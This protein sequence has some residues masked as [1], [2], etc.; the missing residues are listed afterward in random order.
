MYK[1]TKTYGWMLRLMSVAFL[2]AGLTACD[3]SEES[4]NEPDKPKPDV[5]VAEGDWQT[6]LLEQF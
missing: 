6:V 2:L 3:S 5:P 4:D 1:K